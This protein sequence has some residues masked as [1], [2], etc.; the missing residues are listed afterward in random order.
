MLAFIAFLA[1]SACG[2]QSTTESE[3]PADETPFQRLA[4]L[5]V[6]SGTIRW[7]IGDEVQELTVSTESNACDLYYEST[8]FEDDHGAVF[9][10]VGGGPLLDCY[11]TDPEFAVDFDGLADLRL[12]PRGESTFDLSNAEAWGELPPHWSVMFQ[13]PEGGSNGCWF[14]EAT[15]SGTA[16]VT[17]SEGEVRDYPEL[18]SPDYR[19]RIELSLKTGPFASQPLDARCNAAI[20]VELVVEQTADDFEDAPIEVY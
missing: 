20:E 8:Y 3:E 7:Q 17:V 18:V 6:V 16:T 4:T 2:G 19:R 1:C 11:G 9:A 5:S 12:L 13:V 10:P 15:Y 14:D